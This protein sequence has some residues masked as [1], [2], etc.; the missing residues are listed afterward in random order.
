MEGWGNRTMVHSVNS[1]LTEI[2]RRLSYPQSPMSLP[3][4]PEYHQRERLSPVYSR[5]E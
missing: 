4:A 1:G 3:R 2:V 5:L